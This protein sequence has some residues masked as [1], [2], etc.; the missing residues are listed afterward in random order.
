MI[1]SSKPRKQRKFLYTAPLHVRRKMLSAHLSKELRQKYKFRSFPV[2]KGDEVQIMRGEHKKKTGKISR[3]DYK[4][5]RVYIEGITIKS[6]T[7][8][9]KQIAI[10]PSNLRI[11]NL[12]LDDKK[13]VKAFERKTKKE[14]KHG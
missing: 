7:G 11:I 5:Y 13:R 14:I 9:E 1:E 3:V 12:T 10:H 2:R 4:N 6:T 8:T